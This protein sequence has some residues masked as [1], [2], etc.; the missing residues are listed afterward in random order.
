MFALQ[1][2]GKIKYHVPDW[3]EDDTFGMD[4][5]QLTGVFSIEISPQHLELFA[6]ASLQLGPSDM[7]LLD[8]QAVG[9][10]ILNREGFAMDLEVTARA[11]VSEIIELSGMLRLVTNVSG[12]DQE[13]GIPKKF[14][15]DGYI[16]PDLIARRPDSGVAVGKVV[17]LPGSF[18]DRLRRVQDGDTISYSYVVPGGAPLWKGGNREPGAYVVAAG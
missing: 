9:V 4:L 8:L 14:I 10:F 13:V 2:A 17:R 1:A 15:D 6:M 7:R 11:G 12:K 16:P 5:F 3:N 18:V